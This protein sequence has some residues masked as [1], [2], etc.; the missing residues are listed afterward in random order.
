[1][2]SARRDR[3]RARKAAGAP[4]HGLRCPLHQLNLAR[5]SASER[6]LY[7]CTKA[8]DE[9]NPIA[10]ANYP[11]GSPSALALPIPSCR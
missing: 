5:L 11:L 6:K 1:M 2:A 3:K 9:A 8:Y 7:S 10:F 4:G